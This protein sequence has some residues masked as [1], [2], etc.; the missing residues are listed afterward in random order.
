MTTEEL[1]DLLQ[2]ASTAIRAG[3]AV[4]T[5]GYLW[6]VYVNHPAFS[7]AME[8]T[9]KDM[10]QLLKRMV[11]TPIPEM[12]ELSIPADNVIGQCCDEWMLDAFR[13]GIAKL[14]TKHK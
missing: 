12:V 10:I 9:E 4:A 2:K 6:N 11:A 8:I 5:D 7:R 13:T 1:C 14:V 3:V